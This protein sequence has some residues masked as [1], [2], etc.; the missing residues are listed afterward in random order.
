MATEIL[1]SEWSRLSGVRCRCAVCTSLWTNPPQSCEA[2][3]LWQ[4]RQSV[5]GLFCNRLC[6]QAAATHPSH[7]AVAGRLQGRVQR[8]VSTRAAPGLR[9]STSFT[10]TA[11]KQCHASPTRNVCAR[12]GDGNGRNVSECGGKKAKNTV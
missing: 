3:S 10:A 1:S 4:M 6:E 12:C 9:H 7:S 5:Y 8:F 11:S 2:A